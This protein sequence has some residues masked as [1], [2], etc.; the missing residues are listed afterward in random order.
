MLKMFR[1]ALPIGLMIGTLSPA[2]A[3]DETVVQTELRRPMQGGSLAL[4]AVAGIAY[5]RE[6]GG[7]KRVVVTLAPEGGGLPVR[8]EMVL[9]TRQSALISVPGPVGGKTEAVQLTNQGD[10]VS[11]SALNAEKSKMAQGAF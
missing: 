1:S 9:A 2:L 7:G 5:Y 3:Q 11:L 4:G 8:F 6:D 10:L